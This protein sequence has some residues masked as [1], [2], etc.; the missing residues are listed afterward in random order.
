MPQDQVAAAAPAAAGRDSGSAAA[1]PRRPAVSSLI[2]NGGVF[3]SLRI[4]SASATTSTSP[5][6]SF[7]LTVSADRA[8]DAC[9]RPRRRTRAA[10]VRPRPPPALPR[11]HHD[12]RQAVAIAQVEEDQRRRD[13]GR[14]APSRAG[15]PCGRRRRRA[16]R[17]RCG[18]DTKTLSVVMT[19]R[20]RN[21]ARGV[22][23]V[24]ARHRAL[25]AGRAC[26]AAS[27]RRAPAR[28]R[29]RS[30]STR[31]AS[32][33]GA[34]HLRPARRAL[35]TPSAP[36]GRPAAARAA[37]A[38]PPRGRRRRSRRRTPAAR[39]AIAAPSGS[40]STSRSRPAAKPMPGAI[41][42]AELLHEP[43]VA[44]AAEQR[45]LRA[46]RLPQHLER[47]A[48]V[49]VEAAH[50]PVRDPPRNAPTSSR[51]ALHA[52]EVRRARLA[53]VVHRVRQPID[54]RLV[55]RHL[56]VVDP[57]RIGLSRAAGSPGT[58]S[59][60]RRRARRAALPE[61][62]AGTSAQPTELITSSACANAERR[63]SGSTPDRSPRRRPPDRCMPN[64]S[65]SS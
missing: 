22:D 6:G 37:A 54:D 28:R 17:R 18:C 13:R 52:G 42:A 21:C 3:A 50:Q 23:D 8:L 55:G 46:E 35:R 36:A 16:A 64:T 59:A 12:L 49:V 32:A 29:R 43:V 34:L 5:V 53:Q 11:A 62:A 9:R 33:I 1:S 38:A 10:R 45:V 26:R 58:A 31:A 15:R 2:G 60:D 14:D 19:V 56:A 7:G 20:S 4:S 40:A 24:R 57:Q 39:V 47:R 65:T 41:R 44:A 25:L 27:L 30:A 51:C 63:R 61:T 48:R